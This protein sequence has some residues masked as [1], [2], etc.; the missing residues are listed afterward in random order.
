MQRGCEK[1]RRRKI[2]YH[3]QTVPNLASIRA[4]KEK[5]F[6]FHTWRG[7]T[8]AQTLHLTNQN[9]SDK[10]DNLRNGRHSCEPSHVRMTCQ[11]R[12]TCTGI[13]KL[14]VQNPGLNW[15][16]TR[17]FVSKSCLKMFLKKSLAQNKTKA[18][19]QKILSRQNLATQTNAKTDN[20]QLIRWFHWGT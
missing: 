6:L 10:G 4:E 1:R 12:L 8:D 17:C 16:R 7:A 20:D 15:V 14:N 5:L 2:H 19:G 13:R 9:S 11:D 3:M 18:T